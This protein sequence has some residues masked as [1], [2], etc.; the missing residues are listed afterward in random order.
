[1]KEAEKNEGYLHPIQI[2]ARRTGLSSDV[3]RVWERRYKA[4]NPNRSSNGRRFYTDSDLE[5]LL[6]LQKVTRA[7]RRIGDVASLSLSEL[8]SLADTDEVAAAQLPS[9]QQRPTTGAVM[10]YFDECV[11]AIEV[12]NPGLLH[13]TLLSANQTLGKPF[14]LEDLLNPLLNYLRD[15]C[16]RGAIRR[17]QEQF[18]LEVINS[19]LHTTAL[20]DLDSQH[21]LKAVIVAPLRQDNRIDALR[22]AAAISA[23]SSIPIYLGNDLSTDEIV[24]AFKKSGAHLLALGLDGTHVDSYLPN[25]L[26]KLRDALGQDVEILAYG[27]QLGQY[28][29][30]ISEVSITFVQNLGE[31][32]LILDRERQKALT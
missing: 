10:E 23:H 28:Q 4:V 2:V 21:T 8:S 20:S 27:R 19:F 29:G 18:A 17:T 5:K 26:R 1:M 32:R 31:L 11:D 6:L 9:T 3:I 24:Y 15:E 22:L 16:V 13:Q 7:G 12:M 30:I 14:L 25:E